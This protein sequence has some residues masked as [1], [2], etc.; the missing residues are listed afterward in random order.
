MADFFVVPGGMKKVK[1]LQGVISGR[2]RTCE[3]VSVHPLGQQEGD[4]E[5]ETDAGDYH[6]T[7]R[8]AVAAFSL[9][10]LGDETG[11]L[12]TEQESKSPLGLFS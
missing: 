11:A 8:E 3:V 12:K 2:G 5:D 7:Q 9:D 6:S 1:V 10:N 4:E